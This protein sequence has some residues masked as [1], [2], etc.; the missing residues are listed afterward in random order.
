MV[1]IIM[2]LRLDFA[3]AFA[4]RDL[5]FSFSEHRDGCEVGG[6]VRIF[7]NATGT[8]RCDHMTRLMYGAYR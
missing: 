8:R 4:E 2:L 6:C 5:F 7:V 1:S 3:P